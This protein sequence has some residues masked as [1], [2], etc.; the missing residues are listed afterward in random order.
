MAI[1][2]ILQKFV[3]LTLKWHQII[4]F[5]P[6]NKNF[7]PISIYWKY[8][9]IQ[10]LDFLV[11]RKRKITAMTIFTCTIWWEEIR[12]FKRTINKHKKILKVIKHCYTVW[13]TYTSL[14]SLQ[15]LNKQQKTKQAKGTLV[16]LEMPSSSNLN[17]LI[18]LSW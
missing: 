1:T 18:L 13:D 17:P 6:C 15:I 4:Q 2:N 14:W 3:F 8:S 12:E 16:K 9:N 5:L 11:K 7:F 10:S